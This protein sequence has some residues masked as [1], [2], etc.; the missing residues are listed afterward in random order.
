MHKI[1]NTAINKASGFYG[2]NEPA[3][4]NVSFVPDK[5]GTYIIE[6]GS[7]MATCISSVQNILSCNNRQVNLPGNAI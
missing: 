1:E 2:Y 4:Y 6:I 5:S 7:A 3:E